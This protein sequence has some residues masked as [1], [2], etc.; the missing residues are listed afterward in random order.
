MTSQKQLT[1]RMN[2]DLYKQAKLK[3]N[4]KFGIGL[5]PLIKIFLKSFVSQRGVGFYVGDDQLTELFGRWLQKKQMEIPRKG[6]APLPGPKLK[7]IYEL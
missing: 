3:C 4:E 2:A 7:D 1:V 5:S 6:C